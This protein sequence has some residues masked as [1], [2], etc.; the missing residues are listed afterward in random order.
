MSDNNE[1]NFGEKEQDENNLRETLSAK[2]KL[3][4]DLTIGIPDNNFHRLSS[5]ERD[6]YNFTLMKAV[7]L[8]EFTLGHVVLPNVQ[9]DKTM[10]IM[11]ITNRNVIIFMRCLVGD[12]L[13]KYIHYQLV[14]LL[15]H[16][17]VSKE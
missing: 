13:S 4:S 1:E 14:I 10:V 12:P 7:E 6:S 2:R 5:F 11:S 8:I 15:I 9:L 16:I 3:K 17:Q